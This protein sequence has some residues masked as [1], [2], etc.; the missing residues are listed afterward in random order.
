MHPVTQI[1]VTQQLV[2]YPQSNPTETIS[3]RRLHSQSALRI[4]SQRLT[5]GPCSILK[6]QREGSPLEYT[7]IVELVKRNNTTHFCSLMGIQER[8]QWFF[9]QTLCLPL[10]R[11][12]INRSPSHFVKIEI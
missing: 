9:Y 1:L 11:M 7:A 2:M 8:L 5:K 6:I 12:P 3:I 10:P 4:C